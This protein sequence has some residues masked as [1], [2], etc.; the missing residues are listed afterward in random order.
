MVQTVNRLRFCSLLFLVIVL[1]LG[2]VV[3]TQAQ[4]QKPNIVVIWGDDIG[5]TDVSAYSFGMMGFK[6]PNIDRIAKEGMMFTD[7]YAEQSCTAGRSTFITGQCVART[8]LSKVGMPGAKQGL[9][10]QTV[11]MAQVFKELGYATGQFGKNHL[12]DRDEYLPTNHGFDEFYGNLYHLNAEEEPELPDY[13]KDP[14]FKKKYGPR[15]VLDCKADGKI[16]DTGPLTKKRMET[17]DD[18]IQARSQDFIERQVKAKKPFFLWTCFTHMHLRTH[19]KPESIG[20]AG[21]AQGIYHDVMI[22]HDKNVGAILDTLDK[23][24]IA[25]NTIVVYGTDNG[26]HMNTWPDGAM[27]P[28]RNEKDTGWEGAFRVPCMVRWPGKIK[29]GQVSNEI[30]SGLD[31][32][33]TLVAAAGEPDIKDKLLK[34][35]SAMGKTFKN[36]L[37]GYN[38]L[39]FLT[40]KEKTG[41]RKEIWYFS[42]EIDLLAVRYNNW[43]LHFMVQDSPGTIDVWQREFRNLRMPLIFNLRTDPYERATITSNTYWDWMIDHVWLVYPLADELGA[44]LKTFEEYPP[45][46]LPGSFTISGVKQT[47]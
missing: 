29:P 12:G 24:G 43:K 9:Q 28:F 14:E 23:L 7:Y 21:P 44:F 40:G 18:D 34:G 13:P 33:P 15:G 27:T 35:Y 42:D 32:F 45:A 5:I 30:M 47:L 2:A 17:I 37:D 41:P 36:H 11:C 6:T 16:E 1:M 26:P 8:G 46:Q 31:W 25:D 19:A 4:D 20:Q 10:E 39:P 22:D 38:Q 3:P